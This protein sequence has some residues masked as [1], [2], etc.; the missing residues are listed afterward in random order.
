MVAESLKWPAKLQALAGRV[1]SGMRDAGGLQYNSVHF[2]IEKDAK[3]WAMIMGGV[4][5]SPPFLPGMV[6]TTTRHLLNLADR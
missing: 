6:N 3:D 2:R 4:E 1:K 5:V